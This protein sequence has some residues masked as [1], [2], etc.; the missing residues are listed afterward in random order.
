[1][2]N[3]V[4]PLSLL[5]LLIFS[6]SS[7][8]IP[9]YLGVSANENLSFTSSSCL[10]ASKQVL[11]NNGFQKIVQYK[12]S[13]T[14]FAAYRNQSPYQ[15]KAMIK[16]LSESGVIIVV[17]VANQPKNARTKA[18]SLRRQIQQ[19]PNIKLATVVEDAEGNEV[20]EEVRDFVIDEPQENGAKDKTSEAWQEPE[21]K[22]K[23]CSN[24]TGSNKSGCY[25]KKLVKALPKNSKNQ[26]SRE[27]QDTL[28]DRKRCQIRA[29]SSLR[30]SGFYKHFGFDDD[31]IFGKNRMEYKGSIRCLIS[32][33]LV[34]FQVTG[35]NM[36]TRLLLLD[37][38]QRNF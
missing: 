2:N 28:L 5:L 36:D 35:Q 25:K 22:K 30:D 4:C 29:E 27:W 23:E 18:E 31:S 1:M 20:R 15:Y 9:P 21:F 7:Y 24:T 19:D 17:A 14:L 12:S 33:S 3:L 37:K 11:Q 16:C 32:E 6:P 10:S 34:L 8:A 13:S 38:L 26:T